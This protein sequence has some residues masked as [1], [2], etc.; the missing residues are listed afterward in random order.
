MGEITP[1]MQSESTSITPVSLSEY[2]ASR[3]RN[4][5]V[6]KRSP[7]VLFEQ[8]ENSQLEKVVFGLHM[9]AVLSRIRYADNIPETLQSLITEGVIT[10]DQSSELSKHLSGLLAQPQLADWFSNRWEV[11]TEVPIIIPGSFEARMDRL[12]ISNKKAVVIDFKTG[13][14]N[15]KDIQ[16]VEEYTKILRQMNFTEVEGYVLYLRDGEV[17]DVSKRSQQKP[18]VKKDRNQLGLDF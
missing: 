16:Q 13:E 4:Q 3:W 14:H 2:E 9:H 5:L 6:I 12:L 8:E 1:S 18:K 15:K 17:V 10:T 11:K 7:S